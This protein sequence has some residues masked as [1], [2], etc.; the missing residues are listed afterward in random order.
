MQ[1]QNKKGTWF[2]RRNVIIAI[3]VIGAIA[4]IGVLA[5]GN[6][7][8]IVDIWNKT[9]WLHWVIFV[10]VVFLTIVSALLWVFRSQGIIRRIRTIGLVLSAIA[11]GVVIW[12]LST[13]GTI[14][15]CWL[16]LC[17]LSLLVQQ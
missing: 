9:L 12:I 11:I 6:R 10:G 1:V 17:L 15:T 13:L 14:P 7:A 4:T 16:T 5:W 8:S 3:I 2:S